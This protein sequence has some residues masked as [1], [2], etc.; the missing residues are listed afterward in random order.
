[1]SETKARLTEDMK[2]AMKEGEKDLLG[3]LRMMINEVRNAEINDLKEPG[4]LRTEAEVVQI[5]AAYQKQL[6]KS[7][8]EYPPDRQAPL[9]AELS[10][11]ER[12]LPKA[13]SG[14]ELETYIK[15]FLGKTSERT[16][17]VLMKSLQAELVGR[18]DG[19]GLSEAL[20]KALG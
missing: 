19:K 2:K 5:L 3:V 8:A 12:Y 4:R 6:Q 14:A 10:I 20:K 7:L 9:K 15:D 1:M 11:V 17:G 16:F 18:V 13:L